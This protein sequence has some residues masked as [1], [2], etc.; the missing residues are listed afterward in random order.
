MTMEMKK[1]LMEG[2]R[3]RKSEAR[4]QKYE[5]GRQKLEAG[6]TNWN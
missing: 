3:S 4:I 6:S 2:V 5:A 1:G